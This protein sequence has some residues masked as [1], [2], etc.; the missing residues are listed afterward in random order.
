MGTMS[1]RIS[2]YIYFMYMLEDK[3]PVTITQLH[4]NE[5]DRFLYFFM[6]FEPSLKGFQ[7]CM[8][9][10]I[11]VDGTHL[12]GHIRALYSLQVH[13]TVTNKYIC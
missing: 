1:N 3:N 10:V 12:K 5:Y 7:Q 13:R 6:A 2:C 9:L 4:T 8:H 11:A